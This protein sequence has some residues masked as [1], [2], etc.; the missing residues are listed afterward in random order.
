MKS[1][2]VTGKDIDADYLDQLATA[3]FVV[4]NP[5]EHLSEDAVIEALQG[6]QAYLL[7]G[8]ERATARII[9]NAP[10]LELIAFLGVG[11]QSFIDSASATGHGVAITNTPGA[12]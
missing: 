9:E 4:S 6:K 8:L 5:T 7:A 3:G 11:Y 1:I 10:D 12:M 2:L